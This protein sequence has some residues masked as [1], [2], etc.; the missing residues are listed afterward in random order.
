MHGC[1]G[2]A[3]ATHVIIEKCCNRLKNQHMGGKKD[4]TARSFEITVNHRR[5]IL[6]TTQGKSN[7]KIFTSSFHARL[8][9]PLNAV[10]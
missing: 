10:Y 8:T 4:Q 2:S 3:D 9:S 6:A 5:E 7:L 1:I